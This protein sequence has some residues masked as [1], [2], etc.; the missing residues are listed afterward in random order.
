MQECI[1]TYVVENYMKGVDLAL[2][3]RK[4]EGFD[5]SSKE[6][7]EMTGTENRAPT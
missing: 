1:F 6:P 2:L 4:L 5:L 7:T 3:I